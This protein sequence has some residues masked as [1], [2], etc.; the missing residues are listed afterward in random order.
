MKRASRATRTR[1]PLSCEGISMRQE[2][3]VKF[4]RREERYVSDWRFIVC[5]GVTQF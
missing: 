3:K 2:E 4:I 5:S 1:M